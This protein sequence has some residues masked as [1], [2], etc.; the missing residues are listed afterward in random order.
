MQDANGK[1]ERLVRLRPEGKSSDH[2]ETETDP[3]NP[4]VPIVD[5]A[6]GRRIHRQ[7]KYQ[8]KVK[9]SPV[10]RPPA[11]ASNSAPPPFSPLSKISHSQSLL[12][13]PTSLHSRHHHA[14]LIE[15]YLLPGGDAELIDFSPFPFPSQPIPPH[16][17]PRDHSSHA[18]STYLNQQV[19]SYDSGN[20]SF[21]APRSQANFSSGSFDFN[22]PLPP[23]ATDP[24][25]SYVGPS[26]LDRLHYGF[27]DNV[28]HNLPT[29]AFAPRSRNQPPFDAYSST[30]QA[31]YLIPLQQHYLPYTALP[32]Q[33]PLPQ[34]FNPNLPLLFPSHN[35]SLDT[36]SGN[37]YGPP[38]QSPQS[39]SYQY[40][41]S[42]QVQYP[43]MEENPHLRRRY[44]LG[45]QQLRRSHLLTVRQ[46]LRYGDLLL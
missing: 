22:D 16:D 2:E 31:P 38:A 23:P 4:Q 29:S 26:D 30:L 41:P 15:P 21:L 43:P 45:K 44:S 3:L 46:A 42:Y 9:M 25:Q 17:A 13:D 27:H 5:S 14:S 1:W 24:A 40:P 39:I 19:P 12:A 36:Y 35:N 28:H 34:T 18:H 32:S 7:R 8:R 10:D 33:Q 20:S 11:E 37:L 6:K